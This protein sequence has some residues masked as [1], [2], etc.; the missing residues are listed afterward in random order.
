[1]RAHLSWNSARGA[2][3]DVIGEGKVKALRIVNLKITLRVQV[4]NNH[5][6]TQNLYYNYFYQNPKYL[7]I[8]YMDPVGYEPACG[9]GAPLKPSTVGTA[10][11]GGQFPKCLHKNSHKI[12]IT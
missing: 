8:G 5:I 12:S 6:L 2:K 11:R 3:G 9:L 4:P 7:I 10:A 1:M